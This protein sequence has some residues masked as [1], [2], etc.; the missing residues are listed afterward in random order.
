MAEWYIYFI[1]GAA[2][3]SID[4]VTARVSRLIG[5]TARGVSA[6]KA[7]PA[8]WKTIWP[9]C[10]FEGEIKRKTRW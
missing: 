8:G 1:L 9:I 3:G 7:F 10:P 5:N 4:F 2:E 6:D